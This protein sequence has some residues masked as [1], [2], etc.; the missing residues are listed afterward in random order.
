L[1][2]FRKKPDRLMKKPF[3]KADIARAATK[4]GSR[5]ATKST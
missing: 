1:T 4:I 5:A 3:R 2:D